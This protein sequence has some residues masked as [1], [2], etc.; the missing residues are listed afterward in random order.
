[1]NDSESTDP[2]GH[3]PVVGIGASSG[4]LE[5]LESFLRPMPA[6]NGMAFVIITHIGPGRESALADIL[7]R[8]TA[9]AV[10]QAAD[11][12]MLQRDHVYV[13]PT[14][15]TLLIE[16]GRIR[17]RQFND[18]NER[19]PIDVFLASLAQNS[20]EDAIAVILSGAGTDGT[21][22]IK[23]IKEQGGLTLAQGSNGATPQNDSMPNS[24]IASGL[25]DLV[26]P[27]Q[28]MAAKLVDYV[29]RF[30][31][32]AALT[33]AAFDGFDPLVPEQDKRDEVEHVERA[34]L[35]IC[36]HL[37][38][39]LHHDFS[40][41]KHQT[42][43]RRVQ[44]RMQ[45]LQLAGIEDYAA[46]LERDSDEISALFRD[47]LV[48]VTSF[49]R[50]KAVFSILEE[51]II[52][53]LFEGRGARDTIR[54]WVPGCSTGEEVYSLAI[55]LYER[56][57]NLRAPPRI[58]VF[59]TDID[60]VALAVARAG[61]YPEPLLQG[62][63]AERRANC[64]V[65]D[66]ASFVVDK[67]IRELCMFSSHS[68]I[69][70]PPFSRIDLISCR[71]LLI[72]FG[73]DLQAQVIPVF[74]YALR[75]N[76]H[77]VLGT[78]ENVTQ[79]NGLFAPVER[80]QR[81]FKRMGET[82][83]G[84]VPKTLFLPGMRSLIQG[85]DA[86]VNPPRRNL[87]DSTE[88]RVLEQ[89]APAHVVVNP[90]GDIVYYSTRTG[91]YLELPSGPP[92]QQL[93]MTVRR[94]LRLDLRIALQEAAETRQTVIRRQ[95]ALEVDD[96]I[97]M[98]TLTV[99]PLP[100]PPG[101][102]ADV[103]HLLVLFADEAVPFSL[104]SPDVA[105]AERAASVANV[106]RL[107][108]EL[109][110]TRERLQLLVEEYETALEELKSANE[111]LV[112]VNEEVQSTNEELETSKEEIQSINE[113]LH[114]VN[115]ELMIKV[116]EHDRSNTDLRNLF[117]SVQL[118]TVFLDRHLRIRNFT[119]AVTAIFNLLPSDRGRLLTDLATEL[120][121]VNLRRE[122]EAVLES[123]EPTERS[124]T[125]DGRPPHY[126]MRLLPY[127]TS[128]GAVD[129]VLVTF[130]DVTS[131][132]GA[133]E[134]Q[135]LLVTE[136]NHRVRNMLQVVAGVSAQTIK[137]SVS[138]D[139][140]SESFLGRLYA[141][142]RSYELL[143]R[144]RWT[145]VSLSE[146][147]RKVLQPYDAGAQRIVVTGPRVLAKPA[148]ALSLGMVLHELAT[149]AAKYGAFSVPQGSVRVTLSVES[150]A[151]P[152]AGAD[153][154]GNELV[155]EWQENGG[156]PVTPPDRRGLGTELIERQFRYELKGEAVLEFRAGGLRA[157]LRMPLDPRLLAM[158]ERRGMLQ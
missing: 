143:S 35:A 153:V 50:D 121:G 19:T 132:V 79:F 40:G 73:V 111:E 89:F 100:E 76:A 10:V 5:A 131:L 85:I 58:Q 125:R 91:H 147:L 122:I 36:A 149:N 87:R 68:V 140:F 136:L 103:P 97:Q 2:G 86:R 3:F 39:Q 156:P 152:E 24:A 55:L 130:V 92:T 150:K 118:A 94:S 53:P 67:A 120:D 108:H 45:V 142:G 157:L 77:L 80:G 109:R 134:Q 20:G 4:G 27:V 49:F 57:A 101:T 15:A 95:V 137:R 56:V 22:G 107:E 90:E 44:R 11:G 124:V 145:E 139:E 28:D 123:H 115:A 65:A 83:R 51:R 116:D 25:I 9:M 62:V 158:V 117:D 98:V 141:M 148:A 99:D 82:G 32:L 93:I 12:M 81:V 31:R 54:V 112:S 34:R 63:S 135:R 48:G 72:Y 96:R 71:N 37:R 127:R 14:D 18:Y 151:G 42:F 59:G 78:S 69:R 88:T 110:E 106:E 146:L 75:P 74:H 113:E 128:D 154:A 43:L 133:E 129:G 33:T 64:F 21:L 60:E 104:E 47:L 126:L 105:S 38:R 70:D 6:R 17:L 102:N 26:L 23:A 61:R 30:D 41:Y 29:A 114:T 155:I 7:S 144:E 52:P 84:R 16:Q 1:V 8:A 46:L 13:L 66:G 119:P 138:M